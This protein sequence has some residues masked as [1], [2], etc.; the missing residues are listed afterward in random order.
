MLCCDFLRIIFPTFTAQGLSL[1]VRPSLTLQSPNQASYS[2]NADKKMLIRVS[3]GQSV[4]WPV[5]YF[6][7]SAQLISSGP[8]SGWWHPPGLGPSRGTPLRPQ[9]SPWTSIDFF[10]HINKIGIQSTLGVVVCDISVATS[11]HSRTRLTTSRLTWLS[12]E[13][14]SN[15]S[16]GTSDEGMW[17]SQAWRSRKKA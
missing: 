6:P 1:E 3:S 12:P 17:S 5:R 4:V 2:S 9:P 10:V 13:W 7:F 16:I 14:C 15:W 8:M 11:R